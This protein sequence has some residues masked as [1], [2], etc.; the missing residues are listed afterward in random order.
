MFV[1]DI[2]RRGR[3]AQVRTTQSRLMAATKAILSSEAPPDTRRAEADFEILQERYPRR[4]EYGY[5]PLSLFERAAGRALGIL[6]SVDGSERELKILELGAGDGM[7]GALLATAGHDVTLCDLEDWRSGRAK[8][9]KFVAADGCGGL[10]LKPNE[11]D[12]VCSFNAFEHFVDPQVAYKEVF[13]VTKP[14]GSMLFDFGP[15]YCSPWG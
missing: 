10:P 5:D 9:L 11:F 6:R 8:A 1:L 14:S 15:L 7:L 12:F 3:D 2:I 13:R 4:P